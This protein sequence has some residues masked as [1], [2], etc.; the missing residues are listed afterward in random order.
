MSGFINFPELNLIVQGLEAVKIPP[1]VKV[2][3][4][5]DSKKL[6]DPAGYIKKMMADYKNIDRDS[7]KGKRI[8]ITVG[9]RGIPDLDKMIR[10]IIDTLK[11]WGAEPFI[12]PAMGSHGGATAEGQIEVI[13]SFNITEESMGC[14][15][16]SSMEV[17][18]YGTLKCGAPLYCDKYAMEADGIVL[19][20][21]MKPH[22]EFRGDHE[23]GLAKMIAIGIAKHKGAAMF[24]SLGLHHFPEYLPEASEIFLNNTKFLFGIGVVQNAY[25]DIC[26]IEMCDKSNF[27]EVD[28]KLQAESKQKIADFKFDDIDLLIIDEIGKNI[29]GSGMDPNVVG[30]NMSRS[31]FGIKNITHIFVRGLTEE[32]H[33]AAAGIGLADITTRRCLNSI[34]WEATW[35]NIVTATVLAG[36]GKIPM[37][38]NNDKDAI[39][40]AI[41]CTN[42]ID[43]T[44]ARIARI[45][46]TLET[47]YVE[48]SLP[49]YEEIKSNP[50]IEYLEGPYEMKFDEEGFIVD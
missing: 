42:D 1:M 46:N 47:A 23:S 2:R 32:T 43:F 4:V 27:L 44:K 6:D 41:K 22:T 39:L 26:T 45:Q 50:D 36:G 17:V 31:F 40:T 18:Q 35:T 33:H 19:F 13:E 16:L 7:L 12:V 5:Y 38:R 49:I 29:S 9:S 8:A 28:A 37:Y 48:V 15:I 11:M 30:R 25:D 21:K 20:N 34:D 10:S 3:Q 14:P 24:H